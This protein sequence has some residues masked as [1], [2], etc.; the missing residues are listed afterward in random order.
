MLC[1]RT[2][3]NTIEQEDRTKSARAAVLV[4]VTTQRVREVGEVDKTAPF[5][6][7]L[8]G[9][10]ISL[11]LPINGARILALSKWLGQTSGPDCDLI[12]RVVLSSLFAFG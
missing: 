9:A 8:S 1:Y 5:F 3:A 12:Q 2:L 11:C 6:L 7:V 4:A 10:T